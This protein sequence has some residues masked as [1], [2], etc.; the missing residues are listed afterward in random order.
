VAT[1]LLTR[2]A[3]YRVSQKIKIVKLSLAPVQSMPLIEIVFL[4]KILRIE[5]DLAVSLEF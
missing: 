2:V 4:P 5:R 1:C 3:N